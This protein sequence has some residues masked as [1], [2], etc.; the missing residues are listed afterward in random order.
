MKNK[1]L[2]ATYTIAIIAISTFASQYM[3]NKRI[4]DRY[5]ASFN[6]SKQVADNIVNN[7][8]E[9][10]YNTLSS[11]Y[12]TNQTLDSFQTKVED[13]G[14]IGSSNKYYVQYMGQNSNSIVA[15]TI[16]DKSG[17]VIGTIYTESVKQDSGKWAVDDVQ[18]IKQ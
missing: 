14:F 18:L 15:F 9:N 7:K 17:A 1:I 13:S 16:T 3:I 11:D 6:S 10:A 4:N 12:K 5:N 8:L 2:F